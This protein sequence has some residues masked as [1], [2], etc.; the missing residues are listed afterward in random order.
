M[1]T[2][3]KTLFAA[4]LTLVVLT[5]SAFASSDVKSNNFTVLNQVK[6]ITKLE[7]KGN[8]DV[9]LVQ[10]STES[11]KV[12]D[13]YYSK[14]AL[15]QEKDGVLRISS[16]EKERLT[17]TVYVRNLASIEAADNAT[18][19]T[20]GK[21]SF[22]SLDVILKDKATANIDATTINLY[23][24]IKDNASLILSGATTEHYAILGS[25]AKM[26]M[27]QFTA[28]STTVNTIA[29]VYAKVNVARHAVNNFPTADAEV[30]K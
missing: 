30:V 16:F 12:N 21:M 4:A 24:S 18:V 28:D 20:F 2:S 3:I 25:Q 6:N 14:N 1:K 29:P 19:N 27:E 11:V 8:V 23:T 26:S 15:V 7:V 10:A 5:S 13:S 9:I 17:V 22:L